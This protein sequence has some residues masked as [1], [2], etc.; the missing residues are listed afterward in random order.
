MV[1]VLIHVLV[2]DESDDCVN[3]IYVGILKNSIF[4]NAARPWVPQMQKALQ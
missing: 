4:Y 3:D 2:L 1:S